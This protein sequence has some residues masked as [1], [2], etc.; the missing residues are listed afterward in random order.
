MNRYIIKE[1]IGSP[2]VL[3]RKGDNIVG[4]IV[5]RT[6]SGQT[7]YGVWAKPTVAEYS[8]NN[9]EFVPFHLLEYVPIDAD[10]DGWEDETPKEWEMRKEASFNHR[11]VPTATVVQSSIV[12]PFE[13]IPSGLKTTPIVSTPPI[14]PKPVLKTPTLS[15]G[16]PAT[17]ALLKQA[18]TAQTAQT[19][20]TISPRTQ[21]ITKTRPQENFWSKLFSFFRFR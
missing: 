6:V 21:T 4:S 5:K 12:I 16:T 20:A 2:N 1:N 3:F 7:Q 18:K 19:P 17:E 9:Q 14:V 8:R 13:P 15:I 11:H 10:G